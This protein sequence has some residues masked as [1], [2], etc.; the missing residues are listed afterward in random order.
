[1]PGLKTFQGRWGK[2]GSWL[3]RP[4]PKSGK[5]QVQDGRCAWRESPRFLAVAVRIV[6]AGHGSIDQ[7][8]PECLFPALPCP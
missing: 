8:A 6:R 3:V 1:M 2:D 7:P 5:E 4:T